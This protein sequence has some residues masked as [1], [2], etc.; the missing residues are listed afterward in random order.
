MDRRTHLR[1]FSAYL[2]PALLVAA[3]SPFAASAQLEFHFQYGRLVNPFADSQH[4]TPIVTIQHAAQWRLG[5]TFFFLD[6]LDDGVDDGLNDRTFYGEWYPTLSLGKL[7]NR[8]VGVGRLRD[9]SV[10]AGFAVETDAN[11]LK[12]LPGV[13]ASWDVPGFYFVNTDFMMAVDASDGVAKD[14]APSTGNGFVADV[15]WGA[16]FSTGS[17][18]LR[19]SGH[20]EY[21]TAVDNELGEEVRGWILAQPQLAWDLS[22]V[23]GGDGN[24][25]FVG[26]EYQYWRNKLGAD[27]TENVLQ[28]LVI[29]AL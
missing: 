24:K 17:Q 7:A 13:R 12:Y 18:A 14:G 26:V 29:W 5:D 23:A 1:A 11:V 4:G 2:V 22:K 8:K 25:L 28:L 10:I 21:S 9:F 6:Y 3:T 27:V 16:G 15:N 20:A 19:F